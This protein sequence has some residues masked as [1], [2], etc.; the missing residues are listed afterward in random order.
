MLLSMYT[1]RYVSENYE[2]FSRV[3]GQRQWK[4]NIQMYEVLDVQEWKLYIYVEINRRDRK[5]PMKYDR[6]FLRQQIEL[7]LI[8]N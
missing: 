5:E 3:D 1:S 8:W 4:V 2:I 7:D 6:I